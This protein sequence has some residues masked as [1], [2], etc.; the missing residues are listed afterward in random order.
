MGKKKFEI[1]YNLKIIYDKEEQTFSPT[2]DQMIK[3]LFFILLILSLFVQCQQTAPTTNDQAGS[4]GTDELTSN[5]HSQN[6]NSQNNQN[7]QN[8]QNANNQNS[9]PIN[10]FIGV[11]VI[12]QQVESA[13]TAVVL[14]QNQILTSAR[15]IASNIPL[16]AYEFFPAV[17]ALGSNSNSI[18]IRDIKVHP[19]WN[20][21]PV[22]R[23]QHFT[24]LNQSSDQFTAKAWYDL[25]ILSLAD[26]ISQQVPQPPSSIPTNDLAIQIAG[27]VPNLQSNVDRLN[28]NV[29]ISVV[30]PSIFNVLDSSGLCNGIGGAA[31]F[32]PTNAAGQFELI[33]LM[34]FGDCQASG[35]AF[36]ILY[37]HRNFISDVIL[38][39]V[40]ADANYYALDINP[41]SNPN[42][43]NQMMPTDLC[44]V[45]DGFC[46]ATCVNPSDPDCAQDPFNPGAVFGAPCEGNVDCASRICAQ[47]DN[48][49][50]F[51]SKY[52]R[53]VCPENFM[54][55]DLPNTLDDICG[56]K[57][58]STGPAPTNPGELLLMGSECSNDQ[59]CS[60]RVC[61]GVCTE[62]C[63]PMN[64]CGWGYQCQM[65][66]GR[67][68]CR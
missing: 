28:A 2:G 9:S 20:D 39:Q 11:L 1:T 64:P 45:M 50:K 19:L 41:M 24:N 55:V 68:V 5:S 65:V 12:R 31:A 4:G 25:A 15:C 44:S 42:D 58:Q 49:R 3:Q 27:Y 53:D 14:T 66:G 56:P 46:D 30:Q 63:S 7:Q 21:D 29:Q 8:N 36:T 48:G 57:A 23:L 67:S 60:S 62:L 47:A 34:S 37:P 22:S 6:Q 51:C 35:M 16:S 54:C 52:C 59:Q 10:A 17:S 18:A 33:G 32:H 26:P 40:N 43:P 13:C 38:G 61:A